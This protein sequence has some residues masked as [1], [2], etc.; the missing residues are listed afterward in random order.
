VPLQEEQND[1][2][3]IEEAQVK[4]REEKSIFAFKETLLVKLRKEKMKMIMIR[5]RTFI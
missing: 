3:Q 4:E 5:W 2:M 1:L